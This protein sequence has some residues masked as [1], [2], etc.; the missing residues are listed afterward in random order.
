[1][2]RGNG[3]GPQGQ[4]PRTGRASGFC[5]G[6]RQ[7]GFANPAGGRGRGLGRGRGMG[8]Q[9]RGGRGYRN[10]FFATGLPGWMRAAGGA[11]PEG[12]CV[13]NEKQVLTMQAESLRRQLDEVK[14]RLDTLGVK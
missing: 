10:M 4:G 13:D 5:A 6:N 1:M 7:A 14:Q 3:K 2:P 9:G 11:G 8:G 12:A